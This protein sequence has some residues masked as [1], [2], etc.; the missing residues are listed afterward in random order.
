MRCKRG[1]GPLGT[2]HPD[3]TIAESRDRPGGCD[4][5]SR[6]ARVDRGEP[7]SRGDCQS[8]TWATQSDA[9]TH[10]RCF[11]QLLACPLER[12]EPL[13]FKTNRKFGFRELD[14]RAWLAEDVKSELSL[15]DRVSDY[16]FRCRFLNFQ[17][18]DALVSAGLLA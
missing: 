5:K 13:L 7:G 16:D 4:A 15:F 3:W 18:F 14:V 2:R 9:G 10:R 8:R 6:R 17:Y 1:R 11:S 12:E